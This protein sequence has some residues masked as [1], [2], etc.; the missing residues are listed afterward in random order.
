MGERRCSR[1]GETGEVYGLPGST[2]GVHDGVEACIAALRA[3]LAAAQADARRLDVLVS[4]AHDKR[5]MAERHRDRL[6]EAL[7]A[8]VM[9]NGDTPYYRTQGGIPQTMPRSVVV[10]VRRARAALAGETNQCTGLTAIWCP[11][12]GDCRCPNRAQ[13]MDDPECPLHSSDSDHGALAGE[14]E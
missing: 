10:V 11:V 4:E 7:E 13:A 2:S 1:C 9:W 3:Q 6:A 8:C 14:G 5:A 12:H